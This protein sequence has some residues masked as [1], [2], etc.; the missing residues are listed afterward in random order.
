MSVPIIELRPSQFE[1]VR[2]SAQLY[3]SRIGGTCAL[4]ISDPTHG[5]GGLLHW[6]LPA[7]E[8]DPERAE[9]TPALF[10]ESGIRA[11]LEAYRTAGGTIDHAHLALVGG[12]SLRGAGAL[13]LGS[14]NLLAARRTLDLLGLKIHAEAVGGVFAREIRL[15]LPTGRFLI[16]ELPLGKP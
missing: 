5:V 14:R 13:D 7:E 2:G 9:R 6:L 16:R 3:A 11:L 1:V 8:S 4:A 10:A 12:A 15:D